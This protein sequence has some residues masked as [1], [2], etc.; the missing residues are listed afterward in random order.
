NAGRS[1]HRG[2]ELG[3]NLKPFTG[4]LLQNFSV[5]GNLNLSDNYFK[6]YVEINGIDS[7][8][9]IIYGNDY[10]G[11]RIILTPDVITNLSLNYFSTRGLNVYISLQHIGK[12]YLDN[13]EDE[14][15]N[16]SLRSQP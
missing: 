10:S 11:N 1:V 9:N 5:S 6:E 8:G 2:V 15:K 4:R 16:P 7:S 14:R 13:S 3:L 12:Q